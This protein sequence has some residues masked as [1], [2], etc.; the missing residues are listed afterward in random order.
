[1]LLEMMNTTEGDNTV[2]E[3]DEKLDDLDEKLTIIEHKLLQLNESLQPVDSASTA[4]QI[5]EFTDT[6]A[7]TK[8]VISN[9]LSTIEM[10]Q[11]SLAH[12][13]QLEFEKIV[14]TLNKYL[15]RLCAAS[16]KQTTIVDSLLR[17]NLDLKTQFTKEVHTHIR[18]IL[19]N[20]V[21]EFRREML[22]EN[23][24]LVKALGLEV[25]EKYSVLLTRAP[26]QAPGASLLRFLL[27]VVLAN[28]ALTLWVILK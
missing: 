7:S 17:Q 23:K 24:L 13:Q 6:I 25:E 26:A 18:P 28:F 20:L 2:N 1:M 9:M 19:R 10:Q 11:K 8:N 15:E 14:D 27:V 5:Q 22:R 12:I 3:F 21:D 4:R 16:E